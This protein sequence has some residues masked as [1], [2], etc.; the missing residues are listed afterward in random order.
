MCLYYFVESARIRYDCRVAH[1][2]L[3]RTFSLPPSTC[4]REYEYI[5]DTSPLR[6]RLL[7]VAAHKVR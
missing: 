5:P 3:F 6:D 1:V 7:P 4:T 2:L